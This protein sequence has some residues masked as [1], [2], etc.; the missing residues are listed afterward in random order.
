MHIFGAAEAKAN[1]ADILRQVST[2]G[3]RIAIERNGKPRTGV[4]LCHCCDFAAAA[5]WQTEMSGS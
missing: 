1:F 2:G 4:I 5:H 3:P